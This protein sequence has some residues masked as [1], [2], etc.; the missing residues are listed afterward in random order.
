MVYY[1]LPLP[2]SALSTPALSFFYVILFY[3]IS[4]FFCCPNYNNFYLI[5]SHYITIYNYKYLKMWDSSLNYYIFY[6]IN[7]LCKNNAI[8]K[9][10]NKIIGLSL[11]ST[12]HTN[13]TPTVITHLYV[14]QKPP[15]SNNNGY[16]FELKHGDQ[17]GTSVS[18][19]PKK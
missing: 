2:S 15:L 13:T 7:S 16:K 8:S 5:Y 11:R 10:L 3:I 9:V 12:V 17:I 18:F 14:L 19:W 1:R 6:K 4:I